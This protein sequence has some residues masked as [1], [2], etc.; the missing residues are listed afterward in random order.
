MAPTKTLRV[1]AVLYG[2]RNPKAM[3]QRAVLLKKVKTCEEKV[4]MD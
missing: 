4:G 3:S 2:V 1:T